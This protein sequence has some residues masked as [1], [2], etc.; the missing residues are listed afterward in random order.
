MIALL[1]VCHVAANVSHNARAF[2]TQDHR[3]FGGGVMHLVKL[4]MAHSARKQLY[5]YLIGLWVRQVEFIDAIPKVAS[6][7]ILR[8]E[9]RDRERN[10]RENAGS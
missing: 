8:R 3:T 9:L 10:A 2:V 1:N 7:K 4:R 5:D 6:G